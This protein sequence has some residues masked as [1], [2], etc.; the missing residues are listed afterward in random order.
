MIARKTLI[1]LAIAAL[2]GTA[3][4]QQ[5]NAGKTD[6]FGRPYVSQSSTEAYYQADPFD[7]LPQIEQ[8]RRAE[9]QAAAGTAQAAVPTGR[10]DVFGRPRVNLTGNEA[11]FDADPFSPLPQ[12]QSMYYS[13]VLK[14]PAVANTTASRT[15]VFG[16]PYSGWNAQESYYAINPYSPLPQFWNRDVAG[17]AASASAT[18]SGPADT[19]QA[20]TNALGSKG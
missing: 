15:D 20:S 6:I 3:M 16:R 10:T 4:A 1:G 5:S 11:Y 12:L 18:A 9:S 8:I 17:V 2:S 13:S 14:V 19:K 7:P